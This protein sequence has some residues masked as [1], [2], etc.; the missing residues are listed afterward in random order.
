ML[1]T[2]LYVFF[3]KNKRILFYANMGMSLKFILSLLVF[4]TNR[5]K[6]NFINMISNNATINDIILL[7]KLLT[8]H[9]HH[10]WLYFKKWPNFSTHERRIEDIIYIYNNTPQTSPKEKQKKPLKLFKNYKANYTTKYIK[11]LFLTWWDN[12]FFLYPIN[13]YCQQKLVPLWRSLYLSW[14][15]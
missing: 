6:I 2:F 3:S 5:L 10:S 14:K 4:E 8:L 9:P 11:I 7:T 15:H 12:H 13:C 1:I